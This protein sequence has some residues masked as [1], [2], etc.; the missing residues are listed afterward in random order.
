MKKVTV[1]SRENFLRTGKN[2]TLVDARRKLIDNAETFLLMQHAID[3]HRCCFS[4]LGSDD[5][6]DVRLSGHGTLHGYSNCVNP[7]LDVSRN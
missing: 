7:F 4:A 3:E 1:A 6:N 2:K 5:Y